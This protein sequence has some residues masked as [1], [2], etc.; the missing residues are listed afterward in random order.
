[1]VGSYGWL[2]GLPALVSCRTSQAKQWVGQPAIWDGGKDFL[3]T[4]ND[5]E[6][7]V[8]SPGVFFVFFFP[9]TF[10]SASF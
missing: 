10:W 4:P 6:V 7:K 5:V 1:M 8:V 9:V 2:A 3:A